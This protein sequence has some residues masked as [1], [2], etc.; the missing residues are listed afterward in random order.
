MYLDEAGEYEEEMALIIEEVL[1]QRLK[2]IKN[3]EGVYISPAFPK[4]LYVLDENN[5]YKGSKYRHLTELAAR[6]VARRLMPDFISAKKMKENTG[7]YVFPPMG[8]RAFL[9]PWIGEDG[10]AKFYGRFNMGVVSLNLPDVALSADGDVEEFWR[11]FEQR[12]DLIKEMLLKRVDLL[13][14]VSTEISPIHWRHGVL[15]RLEKG[16]TIDS[17]LENGYAT[18]SMGYVGLN[19]CVRALLGESHT[20]KDGEKLALEIMQAMRDK[21]DSWKKETNLGFALYGTPAESLTYRFATKTKERFGEIENITDKSYFTNS[22]H[23]HVQEEID[24]FSKI[25]FEAQF[26]K[27]SSG[28][29]ISYIEV[30]NMNDNIDAVLQIIEFIYEEIQYGE[31]NSKS[32]YCHCCQYDGEIIINDDLEWECPNCGNKNKDRMNVCRRTCG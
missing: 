17:L 32:D 10:K 18:I 6:C 20:T 12:T 2:G 26:Q 14:G 31:I 25:R 30:P 23:V 11:V 7:G 13:R 27:I 24:A 28:G 1:K 5:T 29:C 19:E 9:S 15:A 8:C 4:L 3:E 16:D 22:Y 21:T